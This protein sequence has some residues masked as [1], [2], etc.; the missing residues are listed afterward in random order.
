MV[1]V[2]VVILSMAAAGRTR[3]D[4]EE[5]PRSFPVEFEGSAPGVT[6]RIVGA[7]V[8]IPCGESCVVELEPGPYTG[9]DEP[10]LALSRGSR[11]PGATR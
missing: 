10:L 9:A 8:D 1:A 6:V 4:S 11:Q 2:G 3:A 5:S 7:G